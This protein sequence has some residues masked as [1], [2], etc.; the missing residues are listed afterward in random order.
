MGL[1]STDSWFRMRVGVV[2]MSDS[3]FKRVW[4]VSVHDHTNGV[5]IKNDLML[6]LHEGDNAP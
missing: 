3:K 5:V 4:A 1:D 2:G 6:R